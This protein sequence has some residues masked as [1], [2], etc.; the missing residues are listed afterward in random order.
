MILFLYIK[1]KLEKLLAFNEDKLF[2]LIFMGA[3]LE[4]S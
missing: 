1:M 2:F 3:A 4:I